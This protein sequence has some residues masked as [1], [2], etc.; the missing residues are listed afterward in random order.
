MELLAKGLLHAPNLKEIDVSLNEIGPTG[1]S[2]LC[3]VL[4]QTGLQTLVCN[5]NFLGD[6]IL[7]LFAEVIGGPDGTGAT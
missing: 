4:P 6:P 7:E 1:F 2:K 5:K 3:E